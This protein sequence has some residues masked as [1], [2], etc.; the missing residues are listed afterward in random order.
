MPV[1]DPKGTFALL[2]N[3]S[4]LQHAKTAQKPQVLRETSE[5]GF[6]AIHLD[7]RAL[8]PAVIVFYCP[9]GCSALSRA[10]SFSLRFDR[11]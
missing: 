5:P 1:T 9:V 6:T 11:W 8:A 3:S 2:H 4:Y 7:R 10:A